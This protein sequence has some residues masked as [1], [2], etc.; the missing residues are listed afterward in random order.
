MISY[1]DKL[2]LCS[3]EIHENC[4]LFKFMNLYTDSIRWFHQENKFIFFICFKTFESASEFKKLKM[5]DYKLEYA[6]SFIEKRW[7]DLH[8][9]Y[10]RKVKPS[11]YLFIKSNICLNINSWSQIF[12]NVLDL[13]KTKD[14]SKIVVECYSIEQAQEITNI[15]DQHVIPVLNEFG[16]RQHAYLNINYIS[17]DNMLTKI[18]YKRFGSNIKTKLMVERIEQQKQIVNNVIEFLN[19]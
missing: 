13:F 10:E 17:Y 1:K 19:I 6:P 9:K 11:V 5:K 4:V 18:I 14:R 3:G 7:E 15:L 2:I 12:T 16:D 8:S